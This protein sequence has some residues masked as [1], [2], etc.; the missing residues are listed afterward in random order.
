VYEASI[1]VGHGNHWADAVNG[2]PCIRHVP[3]TA[4]DG[5]LDGFFMNSRNL[6]RRGWRNG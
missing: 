6:R 4:L 5:L 3:A 2:M 1:V